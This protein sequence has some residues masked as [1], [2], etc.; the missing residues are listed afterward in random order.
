MLENIRLSF[1]GIWSHK[2]RSF[3]TMLGI[4]VGIAAVI[5]VVSTI[6]GTNDQIKSNLV[7]DG[8]NTITVALYQ[9][10]WQADFSYSEAPD[11][12]L[13]FT[14]DVRQELLAADGL[15]KASFYNKRDYN[16]SM[17]HGNTQMSSCSVY[18]I[19]TTYFDTAGLQVVKGRGFTRSDLDSSRKVVILDRTAL[20]SGFGG[21][22]AIGETID[23]GGE[24]FTVIGV[25]DKK[26]RFEPVIN[27]VQDYYTY[28]EQSP[29][30]A[31]IPRT[32]W[33]VVFKY[34]E[35]Y[36]A[37]IKA[38]STDE[39]TSVGK[40][41]ADILNSHISVPE[42]ST[43]KYQSLDL[44]E[45]ANQLQQLSSS[46]NILLIGIASI[47]LLVGGI[48]VMNIM[49][50]SVTERTRE[51]GLK[52]ALGAKKRRIRSQFLTEAVI[53]SVIGGLLGVVAGIILSRIISM[54][55]LIPVAISI[56]SILVAVGFSMLIGIIFGL[57]P[58]I[59][60]SNLNPIDALRY[61]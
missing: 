46:A 3:L 31:Y 29:G 32:L 13:P 33:P 53:L 45:A 14:E 54:V 23:I 41:A 25:V 17:F 58:S 56:P 55:A 36:T 19:D 11:G 6:K 60:A 35:P 2:M 10:G 43:V 27:S 4:I 24:P 34:D 21:D 38:A 39:M 44:A 30:T 16:D 51:I 49:L 42:G 20:A 47:S 26:S 12:V 22:E 48:G 59:K 57:A 61:E 9:D 18:G 37:I 8:S 7:G 28:M 1:K 15:Q 40:A 52:K 5:A 50:V